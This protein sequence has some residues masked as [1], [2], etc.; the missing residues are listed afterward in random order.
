MEPASANINRQWL[1]ASRPPDAAAPDFSYR[2][3]PRPAIRGGQF[4]VRTLDFSADPDVRTR[5]AAAPPA[6][7]PARPLPPAGHGP[8]PPVGSVMRGPALGQV[9]E[10][11]HSGFAV[12][13]FVTGILGWQDYCAGD[14]ATPLPLSLL[15]RVH[16]LPRYL[17]ALSPS[18][19]AAC[20]GMLD[21]A[22]PRERETVLVV[23]AAG[24]VG[25]IAAQIARIRGCR[26]IGIA[27][28]PDER[29]RLV[30]ALGLDAAIGGRPEEIDRRLR[31]LCPE[32]V[33]IH[34]DAAGGRTVAH[35]LDHMASW[36]RIVLCGGFAGAGT[37]L[38]AVDIAP[39][40]ARRIRLEG[41]LAADH[42]PRHREARRQLSAWLATGALKACE[43]IHE[44][45]ENL[46][47]A[48]LGLDRGGGI[49]PAMVKV[50]DPPIRP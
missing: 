43:R 33:G 44:G 45:F 22:R 10:S 14:G 4:L 34:F 49:G 7:S 17:G 35:V 24:A 50:A 20:C 42:A 6:D 5:I 12:G 19:L 36:G 13:S 40:I 48:L 15:T 46:P 2:E 27:A 16:P 21:V 25:S 28:R 41:F 47:R 37:S 9:I 3:A 39:L 30:D 8:P 23:D 11:R 32:G 31:Q 1:L 29:G 18:G 38:P 26:V